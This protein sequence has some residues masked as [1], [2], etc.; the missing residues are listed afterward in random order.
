MKQATHVYNIKGQR[1]TAQV[2]VYEIGDNIGHIINGIPVPV[3]VKHS[4][5]LQ[6]RSKYTGSGEMRAEAV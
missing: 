1:F 2:P 3:L 4:R 5:K 6:D